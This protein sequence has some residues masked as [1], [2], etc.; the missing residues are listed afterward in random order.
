MYDAWEARIAPRLPSSLVLFV[1]V[2]THSQN[3]VPS[4]SARAESRVL[5]APDDL[6]G[7]STVRSPA[8]L[9]SSGPLW[10]R[11]ER[12]PEAQRAGAGTWMALPA[13]PDAMRQALTRRLGSCV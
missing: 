4:V 9:L 2:V 12:R 7:A 3:G 11:T 5:G 6:K 13:P 10:T 1:M 8:P